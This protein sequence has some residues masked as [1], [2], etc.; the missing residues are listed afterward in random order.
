[1]VYYYIILY[2][3]GNM[4]EQTE[5][6][7]SSAEDRN[8]DCDLVEQTDSY[9]PSTEDGKEVYGLAQ[10]TKFLLTSSRK[11]M[12]EDL[13]FTV[14]FDQHSVLM[15]LENLVKTKTRHST[16]E[17]LLILHHCFNNSCIKHGCNLND[18]LFPCKNIRKIFTLINRIMWFI[19]NTDSEKSVKTSVSDFKLDYKLNL[20][21]ILDHRLRIAHTFVQ[22]KV[23]ISQKMNKRLMTTFQKLN[24]MHMIIWARYGWNCMKK[25]LQCENTTPVD[26]INH[27]FQMNFFKY[28]GDSAREGRLPQVFWQDASFE[29][30]IKNNNSLEEIFLIGDEEKC[31]VCYMD[32]EDFRNDFAIFLNCNHLICVSCAETIIILECDYSALR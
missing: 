12:G 15:I 2:L 11:D 23:V 17:I 25:F 21:Q 9:K 13:D 16:L 20:V 8:E 19:I 28:Y 18:I 3:P 1:M 31:S 6:K 29:K 27:K 7:T 14:K 10:P 4:A 24:N 32:G 5:S 22:N 30:K 26:L